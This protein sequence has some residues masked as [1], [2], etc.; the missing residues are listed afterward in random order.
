VKHPLL[1][2]AL[3]TAVFS[4]VYAGPAG[5]SPLAAAETLLVIQGYAAARNI[6]AGYLPGG[7]EENYAL[8]L[9]VAIEQTEL[10]DYESYHFRGERFLEIADSVRK[11]LEG[12]LPGLKGKD[13]TLCLFYIANVYGGMSVIKAKMGKWLPA[14]KGS[15]TSVGLLKEAVQRDSAM[16]A[17]L[18]GIGAFHYYLSK[19]FTWLPFIDENSGNRGVREIEKATSASSPFHIAAKNT[20]CWILIDQKQFDRADSVALSALEETPG[21]T[22]FLRIRCMIALWSGRYDRAIEL[23]SKLSEVSLMREPVNWSDYVMAYYVLAGSYEGLGKV[24]EARAAARHILETKIP[25]EFRNIPPVKK[26]LK[27]ILE[28]QKKCLQ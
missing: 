13:S 26:N 11:V 18:L 17:A 6:A 9:R 7:P 24:K 4:S 25:P 27:R 12:R 14:I 5:Q 10:L 15:L 22:I 19:S 23:G 16:G 2:I 1:H 21:S 28:I 20:L 3:I 8:Y